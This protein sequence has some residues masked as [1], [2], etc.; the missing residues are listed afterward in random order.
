MFAGFDAVPVDVMAATLSLACDRPY[1]VSAC[2]AVNRRFAAAVKLYS[3]QV[4]GSAFRR[5]RW[6]PRREA[7]QPRYLALLARIG[8][9]CKTLEVNLWTCLPEDLIKLSMVCTGI[10]SLKMDGIGADGV[11]EDIWRCWG[12]HL[13]EIALRF[14]YYNDD[15][16][17]A[18]Q[19][20]LSQLACHAG[21]QLRRLEVSG[22]DY[23][24]AKP[25]CSA[26]LNSRRGHFLALK[27]LRLRCSDDFEFQEQ[28]LD[29]L[30]YGRPDCV[31]EVET[32][33]NTPLV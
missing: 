21:P 22:F 33:R 12:R 18:M 14:I 28:E 3:E 17:P 19:Q 16:A 26:A 5:V 10:T 32:S 2:A 25:A 4:W 20:V 15:G 9:Q 7:L 1:A 8:H 30:R 27:R 23:P 6:P 24:G 11:S 13:E 29:A 31:I